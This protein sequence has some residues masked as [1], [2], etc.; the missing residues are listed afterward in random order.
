M[1]LLD[2]V[3]RSAVASALGSQSSRGRSPIIMALLALLASRA[4]AGRDN[5]TQAPASGDRGG[6]GG[7]VDRF[8]QGGLEDI[9]NSWISTGANKPI[10]PHQLQDALGSETVNDLSR[11]TGMPRDDLLSQL[12]QVLP[13]V[14]DQLTPQA[15]FR[16]M[17]TCCLVPPTKRSSASLGEGIDAQD[18][19]WLYRS[20]SSCS[21]APPMRSLPRTQRSAAS[22]ECSRQA[23]EK[24][25][26]G[27]PR[28]KYRS[29]FLKQAKK[30]G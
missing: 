19:P 14:V 2:Q 6:L 25:L 10:S 20:P 16:R 23:D 11:E 24:G 8:R 12:S 5:P 28:K 9:I 1:S 15:S 27:K 22:L 17:R 29:K 21:P 13:R 7:L 30:T 4:M 3:I 26:H 18:T